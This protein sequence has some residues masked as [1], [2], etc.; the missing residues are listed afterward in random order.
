MPT[1]RKETA[2]ER[3]SCP[4]L[5]GA[6][7]VAPK[8]QSAASH[9]RGARRHG[10]LLFLRRIG[11]FAIMASESCHTASEQRHPMPEG[12]P[13][14]PRCRQ[15]NDGQARFGERKR[16]KLTAMPSRDSGLIVYNRTMEKTLGVI[17]DIFYDHDALRNRFVT[18]PAG[19]IGGGCAFPDND[20]YI[21]RRIYA[22]GVIFASYCQALTRE[23][24]AE[25]RSTEAEDEWW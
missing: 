16:G 15:T 19:A 3:P 2:H 13:L 21:C 7:G 4:R 18:S 23:E 25:C 14:L 20:R 9:T 1:R 8:R 12:L 10:V 6:A 11:A 22:C 17:G 24:M 5:P